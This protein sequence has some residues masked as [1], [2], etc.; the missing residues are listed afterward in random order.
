MTGST[1][2]KGTT[3]INSTAEGLGMPAALTDLNGDQLAKCPRQL[4]CQRNR[5]TG[6]PSKRGGNILTS[7]PFSA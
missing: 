6:T 7:S 3:S 1:A 2:D 4:P 5:P